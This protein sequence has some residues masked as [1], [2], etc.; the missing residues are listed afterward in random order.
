MDNL[1]ICTC[2]LI[3][4][5]EWLCVPLPKSTC[6]FGGFLPLGIHMKNKKRKKK[7]EK[8]NLFQLFNLRHSC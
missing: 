5:T 3:F 6:L 2:Q 4:R 8:I 1:W 7:K